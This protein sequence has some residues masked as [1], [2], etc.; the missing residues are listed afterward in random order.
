M[1]SEGKKKKKDYVK[2]N[3]VSDPI[4][5][6]IKPVDVNKKPKKKDKKLSKYQKHMKRELSKGKTFMQ[7]VK[8]WRKK[9]APKK[10]L[11]EVKVKGVKKKDAIYIKTPVDKVFK[12]IQDQPVSINKLAKKVDAS[13]DKIEEWGLDLQEQDLVEVVYPANVLSSPKL[14]TLDQFEERTFTFSSGKEIE[15]YKI[16]SDEVPTIIRILNVGMN[17]PIYEAILPVIGVATEAIMDQLAIKISEDVKVSSGEL[18]DPRSMKLLR[19]KFKKEALKKLEG[20]FPMISNKKKRILAGLIV[21][22]MYGLKDIEILM[23]DENIEE[24]SINGSNYPIAVYHRTI[25][26]CMTNLK[27]TDE[28]EVL[29]IASSIGRKVGK[30][31]STMNPL[32][33]AH[34]ISG[35]RVQATL[36]PISSS[37]NTITIRKFAKSP[38]TITKYINNGTVNPEVAALLWLA[39]QY[40]LSVMIAGGTASG[41]TSCLNALTAFI[42]P[43]H[44]VISIEDIREINLPKSAH[45]NWIPLTTRETRAEGS[46]D[47]SML[48]L[49][50]TSLRMRPDRIIVGEVRKKRQAEVLFEAI[51][52]GH[53]VYT[54]LHADTAE[55]A[56]IR[57]IEEPISVPKAELEGLHL[58]AIMF[59]DRRKGFRK[60]LQIAEI[61]PVPGEVGERDIKV[62]LLYRWSPKTDKWE[63]LQ[64]S[65]RIFNDIALHTGLSEDDILKELEEK[66]L[67]LKWMAKNEVLEMDDFGKIIDEYYKDPKAVVKLARENKSPGALL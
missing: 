30:T 56:Y 46:S 11:K 14:K 29:N 41:K 6:V 51:H 61:M 9:E 13:S 66:E 40:E 65:Q 47:V 26:W 48:N 16:T 45:W 28:E 60:L 37:G 25:G 62:R 15:K 33:D 49:M 7:A 8:S 32:L 55:Q 3:R 19:E 64:E 17:V 24:I 34:L 38:W 43:N 2:I 63:K 53:S 39:I 44:R 4:R 57:L 58:I 20:K 5:S 52:T 59:R 1:A 18:I 36:F 23:S 27:A 67:V 42:H 22:K 21:N 31:I 35:D 54:T 12:Q 50:V 10:E